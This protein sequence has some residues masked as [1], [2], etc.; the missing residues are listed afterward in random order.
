MPGIKQ[1]EAFKG[2]DYTLNG[3]S[4]GGYDG[5]THDKTLLSA[6]QGGFNVVNKLPLVLQER[7]AALSMNFQS[8]RAVGWIHIRQTGAGIDEKHCTNQNTDDSPHFS[9]NT[10]SAIS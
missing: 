4:H 3:L 2:H 9:L 1:H 7:A 10:D 5:D 6:R 8:V